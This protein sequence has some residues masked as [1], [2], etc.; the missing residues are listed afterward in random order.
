MQPTALRVKGAEW[1]N[2]H[3]KQPGDADAIHIQCGNQYFL[4]ANLTR[5]QKDSRL[6]NSVPKPLLLLQEI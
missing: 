5:G 1:T 4:R 2:A 6:D 3:V